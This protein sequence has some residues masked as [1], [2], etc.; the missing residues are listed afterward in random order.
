MNCS[1]VF[2]YISGNH[3]CFSKFSTKRCLNIL[4]CLESLFETGT[5]TG[6]MCGGLSVSHTNLLNIVKGYKL[7]SRQHVI[8]IIILMENIKIDKGNYNKSHRYNISS[9]F[10]HTDMFH[11]ILETWEKGDDVRLW[12]NL[13]NSLEVSE[14]KRPGCTVQMSHWDQ[15]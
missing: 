1:K 4:T 3:P 8:I 6:L 12:L 2:L 5:W 9:L 11:P 7:R 15:S 14:I 10:W 13:W